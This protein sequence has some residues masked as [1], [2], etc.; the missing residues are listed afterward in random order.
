[1]I[2]HACCV[3]IQPCV[4][5]AQNM[6]NIIGGRH[7]C[8]GIENIL[9]VR[10]LELKPCRFKMA[11]VWRPINK[12]LT[13]IQFDTGVLVARKD[14]TAAILENKNSSDKFER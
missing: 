13:H 5:V 3:S 4:E 10:G 1:M 2:V 6:C 11:V 12:L 9:K 14:S 7:N 8:S